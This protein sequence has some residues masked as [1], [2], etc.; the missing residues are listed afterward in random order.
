MITRN[1]GLQKLR[2][3][4]Y[5]N[6]LSDALFGAGW[7]T[8][9]YAIAQYSSLKCIALDDGNV[10]YTYAQSC[11]GEMFD[12]MSVSEQAHIVS[13]LRAIVAGT[14]ARLE[15]LE[16][17]LVLS[18]ASLAAIAPAAHALFPSGVEPL[19]KYPGTGRAHENARAVPQA[20]TQQQADKQR[21]GFVEQLSQFLAIS[22]EL[23]S[24][25]TSIEILYHFK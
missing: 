2:L 18:E 19:C 1:K 7:A 15:A 10:G 24:A 25:A 20:Q 3:L 11:D 14:G 12:F 22:K 6:P 13:T 8:V 16:V 4:L 21:P 5:L 17:R 9:A 23:I